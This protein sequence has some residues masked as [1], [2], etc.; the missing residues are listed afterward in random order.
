[1]MDRLKR[2]D[3]NKKD[4]AQEHN[5]DVRALTIIE[6][7][8]NFDQEKAV[9]AVLANIIEK[10]NSLIEL[11]TD[12][13]NKWA[14]G[15]AVKKRIENKDIETLDRVENTAMKR[16]MLIKASQEAEEDDKPLDIQITL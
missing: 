4:F 11:S 12:I 8:V 3:I 2:P 15:L 5:I 13:K 10:D 1:M 9:G 16:V 6:N 7:K 14:E